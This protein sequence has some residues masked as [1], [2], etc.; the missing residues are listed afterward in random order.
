MISFSGKIKNELS[1][2]K[3]ENKNEAFA[4]LCGIFVFGSK[5]KEEN[6]FISCEHDFSFNR[7]TFL[8]NLVFPELY[9]EKISKKSMHLIKISS[10]E[11]F[12]EYIKN[13]NEKD[14]PKNLNLFLAGAFLSCGSIT[15]PNIDYHLEF[16]VSND[17]LCSTLMHC[18][19]SFKKINFRPKTLKRRNS[20]SIYIKEN[21]KI[22]D[23]LVL[24]GAKSCA[25]EFMQVKM[26]KEVRNNINRSINFETANLSKTTS[27]S[28]EH[29]KAIKKIMRKNKFSSLPSGLKE[30]A[31]L[32]LKHPYVSLQ[33]LSKLYEKPISKSGV[34]HRLKKL[35]E[36]SKKLG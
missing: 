25:M 22:E 6:L 34:N 17:N 32:R 35:I 8:M 4:E 2:K 20:Y 15:N 27:S 36:I 7:I 30:T 28:S 12:F 5:F 13:F 18:L 16:N 19:N 33:E 31:T 26:I 3:T 14:L 21:E 23:F 10:K 1:L 11:K 29:I 9:F 24:I